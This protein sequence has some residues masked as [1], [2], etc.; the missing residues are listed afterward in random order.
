MQP[1]TLI[2]KAAEDDAGNGWCCRQ[3]LDCGR[4]RDPCGALG[5]ETINP[6]RN[7]GKSDRSQPTGLAELDGPAI[8]RGQRLVFALPAAMPYR[9]H[10]VN[11]VPRRQL[12][13]LGDFGV[14]GLAAMEHAAFGE[15]PG[16]GGAVDGAIDATAAEQRGIG[17]VDDGVNA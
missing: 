5:G 3:R 16:P 11:H 10:G 13:T 8:A 14:A 2:G 4:D 12:V 6:S 9:T 15:K 7:S 17:G 1:G